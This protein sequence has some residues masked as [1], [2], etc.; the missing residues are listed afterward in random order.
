MVDAAAIADA[1]AVHFP[2]CAAA[3]RIA[4]TKSGLF[5]YQK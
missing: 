4:R 3:R 1:D 2:P 5:P